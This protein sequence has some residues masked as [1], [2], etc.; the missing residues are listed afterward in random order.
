MLCYHADMCGRYVIKTLTQA[1][2]DAFEAVLPPMPELFPR[3][4]VAPSQPVPVVRTAADGRRHLDML[5]WGLI[6]SW[7]KDAK[8]QPQPINVRAETVEHRPMFRAPFQ[9]RRC[10]MAADGFY[11]WQPTGPKAKRPFYIHRKDDAPFAFAAI[12]DTWD[13][14]G[15]SIESCALL[16]TT[17]N[18]LMKPIH[19]RMPVILRREDYARWLDPQT[20]RSELVSL[21]VP[22]ANDALDAYP[23]STAVNSPPNDGPECI[24]PDREA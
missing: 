13:K 11:E 7:A 15:G 2:I 16:T 19:G 22:F 8:A 3:Y 20:P 21:L 6:P 5:R 14:G 9:R 17:P 1:I 18:D 24:R 10:L 23:V 4:N 12:W